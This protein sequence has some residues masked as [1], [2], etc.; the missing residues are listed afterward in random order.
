MRAF[1]HVL[2]NIRIACAEIGGTITLILLIVFGTYKAWKEF[3][4]KLFK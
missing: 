3:I 2:E 4:L 1:L